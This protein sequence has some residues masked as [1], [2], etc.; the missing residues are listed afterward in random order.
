MCC[1]RSCDSYYDAKPNE[2]IECNAFCSK[3][4][5]KQESIEFPEQMR[6]VNLQRLLLG[7]RTVKFVTSVSLKDEQVFTNYIWSRTFCI[8][9]ILMYNDFSNKLVTLCFSIAKQRRIHF[10]KCCTCMVICLS[11]LLKKLV[12]LCCHCQFCCFC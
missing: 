10:H 11:D 2:L 1:K 8:L 12:I 9:I 7:L 6:F 3:L 4:Y 5:T